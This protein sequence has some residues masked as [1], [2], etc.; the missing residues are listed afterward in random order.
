M[1]STCRGASSWRSPASSRWILRS[2]CST[3]RRL[4]RMPTGVARVG[5]RDRFVPGRRALRGDDHP[6]HG[7]RGDAFHTDRR[8]ARGRGR[9]RRHPGGGL[10][11]RPA[12]PPGVDR[13]DP[14]PRRTDR[15]AHGP[16]GRHARR[17]RACWRLCGLVPERR[18]IC[19]NSRPALNPCRSTSPLATTSRRNE[20][21]TTSI[22]AMTSATMSGSASPSAQPAAAASGRQGQEDEP[23]ATDQARDVVACRR[24][25]GPA[26]AT[27]RMTAIATD[28]P[29]SAARM[30]GGGWTIAS[31]AVPLEPTSVAATIASPPRPIAPQ[32]RGRAR[33]RRR[34]PPR[35]PRRRRSARR[36]RS[37]AP[38][39][40]SASSS[41]ERHEDVQASG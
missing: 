31:S 32:R 4:A 29:T 8:H 25:A 41:L 19:L 28:P 38:V 24:P 39:A 1:T 17:R 34:A 2:S 33:S 18:P 3:N 22:P 13:T 30:S 9:S 20:V 10:R 40:G 12:S 7:V 6:R 35:G 36:G 11:T 16:R 23:H 37:G 15:G 5:R 26:R 14:A 21:S 27:S